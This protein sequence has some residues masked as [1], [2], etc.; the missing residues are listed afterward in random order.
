MDLRSGGREHD[1]SSDSGRAE[2]LLPEYRPHPSSSA[3]PPLRGHGATRPSTWKVVAKI[4][5]RWMMIV[6]IAFIFYGVLLHYQGL[7]VMTN[8]Q[9]RVFN[10]A[11]TGLSI[12]FGIAVATSLDGMVGDLRWWILSR[13]FRS[14]HKVENILQADSMMSLLK[15]AWRTRRK[16][17]HIA[18]LLW[19]LV[20]LAGNI[21]NETSASDNI[22]AQQFMV[23]NY[24]IIS[25]AFMPGDNF[26]TIP[27]QKTIVRPGDTPMYCEGSVCRYVFKELSI[28]PAKQDDESIISVSTKRTIDAT[29]K[30]NAWPVVAGGDGNGKSISVAMPQG[31]TN[32]SIPLRIG[33]NATMYICDTSQSCGEGCAIVQ[34]FEASSRS[35]WY[36]Q[37]NVT[38]GPVANAA[39]PQHQASTSLRA[40]VAGS[41]A[42]QGYGASS[43][44]S[45]D[46]ALIQFQ[47][48]PSESLFGS[49]VNGTSDKL[50]NIISRFS[51]GAM[52]A[53]AD[54]NK[55]IKVPGDAPRRG[56]E[57]D[58]TH[59]AI[60]LFILL[61]IIGMTLTLEVFM[62]VWANRVVV[63]PDS[64]PRCGSS[65]TG[66]D[67]EPPTSPASIISDIF[68]GQAVV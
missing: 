17:I 36:Y 38:V 49:A 58:I 37:C 4:L 62:A 54:N 53:F 5:P 68:R 51:I 66:N 28:D 23:N 6:V 35:P 7:A 52:A 27:D 56:I 43:L 40:L 41:I 9:K 59:P 19:G 45:A 2:Q 18:V 60:I 31:T 50:A 12:G 10:G 65:P 22:E 55:F 34:A 61:L 39:M 44:V 33:V 29:T 1:A 67:D 14:R 57:L 63:P 30:C 47:T 11:T 25:T 26:S 46:D 16:S 48:Y 32:V 13:R 15:L 3:P 20:L 8:T 42:L 64:P 21:V 24:G